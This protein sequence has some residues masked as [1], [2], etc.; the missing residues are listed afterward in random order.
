MFMIFSNL[1][2]KRRGMRKN[3]AQSGNVDEKTSR[4][5]NNRPISLS[6]EVCN[7][8]K[9]SRLQDDEEDGE[10]ERCQILRSNRRCVRKKWPCD[11][12]SWTKKSFPQGMPAQTRGFGP[13]RAS[14]CITGFHCPGL[15]EQWVVAL[16]DRPCR[17]SVRAE[18]KPPPGE[19]E[20]GNPLVPVRREGKANSI[21]SLFPYRSNQ[22]IT[23]FRIDPTI[24]G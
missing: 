18:V 3:L 10:Q 7:Q 15:A 2:T 12:M 21:A 8:F 6:V 16:G 11:N 24:L 9:T 13:K 20:A 14:F 17:R 4:Y 19:P 5:R 1:Y 23:H 22:G